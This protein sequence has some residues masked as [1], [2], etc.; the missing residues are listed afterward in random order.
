MKIKKE[1]EMDKNFKKLD[2]FSLSFAHL[3]TCQQ[4]VA[5][6]EC[7]FFLGYKEVYCPTHT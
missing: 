6:I 1:M 2:F 7:V 4:A 3:E 5:D